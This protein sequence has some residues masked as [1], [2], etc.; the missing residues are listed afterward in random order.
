M[1]YQKK[2]RKLK[3]IR[4]KEMDVELTISFPFPK[5]KRKRINDRIIKQEETGK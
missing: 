2:M 3:Q 4:N 5:K 1:Q